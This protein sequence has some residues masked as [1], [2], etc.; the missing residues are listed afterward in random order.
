VAAQAGPESTA[1]SNS[2]GEASASND[3]P[4]SGLAASCAGATEF[5]PSCSQLTKQRNT[6]K[7]N[8][9]HSIRLSAAQL[10]AVIADGPIRNGPGKR[11]S[12]VESSHDTHRLA[13][14]RL[15]SVRLASVHACAHMRE[16]L[17]R[18]L[19]CSHRCAALVLYDCATNVVC[20]MVN[21]GSTVA[22]LALQ[23]DS[24]LLSE[25]VGAVC[26]LVQC[27]QHLGYPK[28]LAIS[29]KRRT[30]NDCRAEQS[31]VETVNSNS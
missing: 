12:D 30:L 25:H 28:G 16:A 24:L 9:E 21:K 20:R 19:R 18:S 23:L 22:L 13:S 11:D 10:A 1:E 5:A 17:K 2:C 3:A 7:T 14:V 6:C 4:T 26:T 8:D 29:T 15:A 31:T 27:V